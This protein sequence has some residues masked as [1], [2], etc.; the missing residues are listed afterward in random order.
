LLLEW[1]RVYSLRQV[2]I[3][4]LYLVENYMRAGH[5]MAAYL[6]FVMQRK[7]DASKLKVSTNR[8]C[9]FQT[10]WT[11]R[12]ATKV[13]PCKDEAYCSRTELECGLRS[14]ERRDIATLGSEEAPHTRVRAGMAI[15]QHHNPTLRL[16]LEKSCALESRKL[17]ESAI[18]VRTV[19]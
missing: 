11:L 6:K 5:T 2:E 17:L 8:R 15:K 13:W 10:A 7:N 18:M 16:S 14:G 3:W 9:Y 1:S 4:K 12:H 19:F